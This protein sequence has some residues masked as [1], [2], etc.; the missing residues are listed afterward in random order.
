MKRPDHLSTAGGNLV[1]KEK[2]SRKDPVWAISANEYPWDE[3]HNRF[4]D[5]GYILGA[6]V[7]HNVS[8][9]MSFTPNIRFHDVFLALVLERLPFQAY[10][11]NELRVKNTKKAGISVLEPSKAVEQFW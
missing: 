11:F 3:Y 7:L 10:Q 9:V 8:I 1:V 4:R 2:V 6:D 5:D